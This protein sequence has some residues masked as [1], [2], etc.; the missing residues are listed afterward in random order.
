MKHTIRVPY[1]YDIIWASKKATEFSK[2]INKTFLPTVFFGIVLAFLIFSCSKNRIFP[3]LIILN[4]VI[5]PTIIF[6]AKKRIIQLILQRDKEY[7]KTLEYL[8]TLNESELQHYKMSFSFSFKDDGKIALMAE[9]LFWY[10][11]IPC[12]IECLVALL[13]ILI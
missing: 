12:L 3:F 11:A 1:S 6:I 8:S 5:A 7:I 10:F 2:G 13:L 9:P 4:L